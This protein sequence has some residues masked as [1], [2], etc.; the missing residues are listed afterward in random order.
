MGQNPPSSYYI[1][2][3][4]KQ[5]PF[6]IQRLPEICSTLGF[7]M[8]RTPAYQFIV[9]LRDYK[10]HLKDALIVSSTA[11]AD[12]G[13]VTRSDQPLAHD[14]AAKNAIGQFTTTDFND[15]TKRA[16][17]P[18]KDSSDDTSVI[19]FSA[20]LSSTESVIEPV[21]G[22]EIQE[23]STP[24]PNLL[25]LNND[26]ILS[27]W[28]FIYNEAVRQKIPYSGAA[29]ANPAQ[30]QPQQPAATPT[31]AQQPSF[32]QSSFGTPSPFG[33]STFGKPSGRAAFGNPSAMGAS[34]MGAT[35]FGKP[36]AAA[37][38][39]SPSQLGG[40]AAPAFGKPSALVPR[41]GL[42]L[43]LGLPLVLLVLPDKLGRSLESLGLEQWAQAQHSGS[44][45]PP[46]RAFWEPV[47]LLVEAASVHSRVEA[48]LEDLLRPSPET[49]RSRK[50]AKVL[51]PKVRS[52]HLVL[53]L[54]TTPLLLLP[55]NPRK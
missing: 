32:G 18:L 50:P 35:A 44:R 55:Q 51:S 4:R 52:H 37:S 40:G 49:R 46:G 20:D 28:W 9:R 25:L 39:G 42:P 31:P 27:S 41:S 48:D 1:I 15:D 16:S 2:T 30:S 13:L 53:P 19:G 10:P 17:I 38:F 22:E 45:A 34:T 5:A 21:A 24:L 54:R 29:P 36:S 12:V 7:A 23:S 14:D 11:S 47:V 33:G 43:N 6:L 26:G 3:R 8:K